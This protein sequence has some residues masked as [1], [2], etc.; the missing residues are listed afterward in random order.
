MSTKNSITSNFLWRFVERCGAQIVTFVV[1]I[2]LARKLDPETYGLIALVTVFTSILQVFVDSGLA[3]SLIQKRDSDD[4]DFSSVFY[5]NVVV[6]VVLYLAMYFLAPVIAIFYE[7]PG[8]TPVI[9]VLSLSLIISGVKN[10]Q[11][12][13]VSKHMLFQRFFWSSLVGTISSAVTGIVMAYMGY[14]IWALVGQYL[15]NLLLATVVLWLT[16]RWR[17]KLV[18]SWSRLKGLLSFGW[19][20]LVSSLIDNLYNNIRQL[21]IGKMY[22]SDDL[23]FYNQGKKFPDVIVSNLGTSIDSILLPTMSNVQD[24]TEKVKLL[25]RKSVRLGTYLMAPLMIGLA[26]VAE[27]LITVVLTEKWLPSTFFMQMFCLV[28]ILQPMHTANL[29]AIKAIGRSD[30]FLVFDIIKRIISFTVLFISIWFGV[31]IIALSML[32]STVICYLI[33]AIPNKKLFGYTYKEQILDILPPI[34]LSCVMGVA[35]YTVS[36]INVSV[37]VSLALQICAGI[38]VYV[39][40]SAIFKLDAFMFIWHYIK[41]LVFKA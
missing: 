34:A 13:Y 35:V 22:S 4:I 14:G 38:A 32:V 17:P 20:L 12:A 21:I 18:F 8:L 41:K 39:I 27:P 2:I 23:A 1:S 3:N 28:F 9:R 10:I 37:I 25:T 31:K 26:C 15:V 30:V 40:G 24:N 5:F 6:C 19:K 7:M 29:N 33:Y 36:L 16:V 11:Q